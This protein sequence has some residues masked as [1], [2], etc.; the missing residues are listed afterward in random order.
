MKHL[1]LNKKDAQELV[2]KGIVIDTVYCYVR[3]ELITYDELIN[4]NNIDEKD[5]TP[6]PML[7]ELIDYRKPVGSYGILY[8]LDID[9]DPKIALKQLL[10]KVKS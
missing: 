2:D 9:Q 10:I 8:D 5:V 3:G 6:A 7:E 1:V 4:Y